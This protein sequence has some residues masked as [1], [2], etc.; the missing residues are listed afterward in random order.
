MN[1]RISGDDSVRASVSGENSIDIIGYG[2]VNLI[3][4]PSG[5]CSVV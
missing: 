1:A 2:Y 4:K 3:S 5:E